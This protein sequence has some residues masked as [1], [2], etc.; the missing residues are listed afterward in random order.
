M[1]RRRVTR[2]RTPPSDEEHD[3]GFPRRRVTRTPPSEEEHDG[4]R[5]RRRLTR[6]PVP[7]FTE[8]YE[9]EHDGG[10]QRDHPI[11][12]PVRTGTTRAETAVPQ[13]GRRS[14]IPV[15]P[16]RVSGPGDL[17]Y[18]DDARD[19][20]ERMRDA[21]DRLMNIAGTAADNED[22]REDHFRQNEDE[23]ERIFLENEARREREAAQKRGGILQDP[24]GLSGEGAADVPEDAHSIIGSM[25]TAAH[26]AASRPA[27]E[28]LETVREEMA[29][30]REAAQAERERCRTDAAVERARL[31]E[32][33]G[34]RVRALE[35][36]LANVKAELE[37]ERQ[38][39]FTEEAE[40]RERERQE[41]LERDEAVRAQLGD[42]TNLVQDQRDAC[43]RKKELMDE[44]WEESQARRADKDSKMQELRD[45]VA[46]LVEDREADRV[47]AEEERIAAE[48]RPGMLMYD[49]SDSQC[50]TRFPLGIDRVL[51]EL[52]RQNAE[53]RELL[54]NLS[55]GA[56][57][58]RVF[59]TGSSSLSLQV[60]VPIVRDSMR[61][62]LPKFGQ[63]HKNKYH[64][65]CRG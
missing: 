9:P 12:V 45:M 64:S 48:G 46:K 33:H 56:F 34:E 54:N 22:R 16:P 47:R 10:A 52:T 59:R 55:D 6:S 3:G 5:L 7:R 17:S 13:V 31:D 58:E 26:D 29:R 35:A 50:L 57:V 49:S 25:R 8:P 62:H 44:R 41:N 53:Q 40:T 61:R 51:E 27:A 11:P 63:Q 39:R 37:N 21:E 18:E 42:I 28:I 38:L 36:E 24:H 60:G 4:G 2:V 14:P 1:G 32:E 30:E 65:T 20:V 19:R 23:R 43:A 15:P